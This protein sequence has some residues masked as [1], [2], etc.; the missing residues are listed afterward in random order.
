MFDCVQPGVTDFEELDRAEHGVEVAGP[1]RQVGE[2][3]VGEPDLEANSEKRS[4]E[5]R[6]R[7]P[8]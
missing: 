7:E 3:V 8:V 2:R 6:P 1:G 5:P 4:A